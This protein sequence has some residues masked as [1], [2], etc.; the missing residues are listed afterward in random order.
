MVKQSKASIISALIMSG[1]LVIIKY[2]INEV[3]I[4]NY[5]RVMAGMVI[6]ILIILGV[7]VY[8]SVL[9]LLGGITKYELDTVSPKIYELMPNKLKKKVV[10]IK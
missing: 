1:V 4:G 10:T 7:L 5:T 9:L 8:F 6:F 3:F 2:I